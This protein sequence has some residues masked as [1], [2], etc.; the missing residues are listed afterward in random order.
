MQVKQNL[1]RIEKLFGKMAD[2]SLYV[3]KVMQHELAQNWGI[4]AAV[5]YDQPPEFFRPASLEEKHKLF[6]GIDK[7]LRTPYNKTILAMVL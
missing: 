6:C 2:G 7:S 1:D 3:T 4:S 5:L